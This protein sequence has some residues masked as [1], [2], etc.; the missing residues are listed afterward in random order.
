MARQDYFRPG[1]R[2]GN[3]ASYASDADP[4]GY[5]SGAHCRKN[6]EPAS[7]GEFQARGKKS[8]LRRVKPWQREI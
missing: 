4:R 5:H 7:C 6:L 3:C 8:K 1:P 2:C